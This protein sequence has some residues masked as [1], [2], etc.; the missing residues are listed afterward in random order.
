[1]NFATLL[2]EKDALIA[3]QA[4]Q[5]ATLVSDNATLLSQLKTQALLIGKLTHEL[6]QIKRVMF[7]RSSEAAAL[8]AVQS[9]LFGVETPEINP[10]QDLHPI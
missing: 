3:I 10:I 9:D 7:G 4:G 8:L 6:A 5:I 2:A 1:M